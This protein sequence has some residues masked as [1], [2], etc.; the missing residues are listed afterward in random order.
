MLIHSFGRLDISSEVKMH[1]ALISTISTKHSEPEE[2]KL[3]LN[4]SIE[5]EAILWLQF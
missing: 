4:L 1:G 2:E 5:A 3:S